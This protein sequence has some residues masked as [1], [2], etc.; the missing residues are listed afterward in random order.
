MAK[1][2][3]RSKKKPARRTKKSMLR[4]RRRI[5][6][7]TIDFEPVS[8]WPRSATTDPHITHWD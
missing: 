6:R 8:D 7:G 1:T 3:K 5:H 4:Q 2:R